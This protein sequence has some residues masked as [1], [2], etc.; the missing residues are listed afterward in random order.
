MAKKPQIPLADILRAL[1]KKD[2]GFYNRLTDEQ[3][4]AFSPWLMLR[5]ASTVQEDP[6][7]FIF[8]TNE[9]L[10]VNYMDVK[11]PELQWL[12]LTVI[13]KGK[14]QTH[15]WLKGPGGKR[16]TDKVSEMLYTIYPHIKSDEIELIK[17]INSKDELKELAEANGYDDKTIKDIF[18]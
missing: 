4:K 7:H 11:D 10:N 13:G 5:Y 12:L 8:M 15:N 6:E 16:K 9:I 18:K 2:R 14:V 3:K 1:D 17:S